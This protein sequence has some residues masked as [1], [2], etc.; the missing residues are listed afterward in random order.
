VVNYELRW[1][2]LRALSGRRTCEQCKAVFHVTETTSRAAPSATLR[3]T[4]LSAR[5]RPAESITV[6]LEAYDAALRR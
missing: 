1:M 5:R 3:R 4:A 6:R 2:R